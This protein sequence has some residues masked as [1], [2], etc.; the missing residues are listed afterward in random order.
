[1][2]SASAAGEA[3]DA[4][5][6]GAGVGAGPAVGERIGREHVERPPDL[7]AEVDRR[8]RHVGGVVDVAVLGEFGIDHVK[9][10]QIQGVG[11]GRAHLVSSSGGGV[12]IV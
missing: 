2:T 4:R 5:L 12:T 8:Q 3:G 11:G 10:Q 7:G 9:F 1:M 6:D